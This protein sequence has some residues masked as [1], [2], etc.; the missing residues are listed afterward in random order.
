MKERILKCL[1]ETDDYV[2]GQQLCQELNVSRTAVWKV[3][4]QLKEE[5]YMIE[6]VKNRGYRL[7][8][9]PDLVTADEL[10]SI[11]KT[12]WAGKTVVYEEELVSTNQ[13][14]KV[15]AEQGA[16]HGTLVVAERQTAGKGRRGREWHSPKGSGI[17]MSILLRPDIRPDK[18]SMLTIVAAMAV[19]DA[20]SSRIKGCSIKWPNDI[21]I[22]GRKVCGILTEMSSEPDHIHYVVIGIGINVNT[23]NFPEDIAGVAVSMRTASGQ[24][25]KRS[26]IIADVWQAFERYYDRFMETSDLSELM[27]DYN[28]RLINDGQ[29]VYIEERGRKFDGIA[30][31]IDREGCLLVRKDDGTV[32]SVISGEVS[33]RG[34]L[35]YV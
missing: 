31:G 8:R 18:A 20:I 26:E 21:V 22:D 17:W 23:E 7:M 13:T 15:I 16:G 2:S 27:E 19:Y 35:G 24:H 33:V 11:L 1:R 6:A 32:I 12:S 28:K 29:R 10:N 9:T 34:V 25:F 30:E 4:N 3:M 5:G 14:A